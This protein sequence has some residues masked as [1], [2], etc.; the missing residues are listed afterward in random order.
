MSEELVEFLEHELP[1]ILATLVA[2][3]GSLIFLFVY[4]IV[5]G[6]IMLGLLAPIAIANV[7]MGRRA[8]RM[9]GT[10]SAMGETGSGD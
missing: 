2:R 10:L 6:L 1:A 4:D 7:I 3:I 5:S 9:N 8:F